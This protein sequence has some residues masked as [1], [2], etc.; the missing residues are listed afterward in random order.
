LLRKAK[1]A[2]SKEIVAYEEEKRNTFNQKITDVLKYD[3]IYSLTQI[4]LILKK[5]KEKT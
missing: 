2:A 1:E 4:E 5:L 3:F